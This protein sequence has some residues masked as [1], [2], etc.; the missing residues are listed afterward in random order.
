MD[1]RLSAR[2]H[3]HDWPSIFTRWNYHPEYELHFV[4]KSRGWYIVGDRVGLFSPGH[5]VLIG[6][7]VPHCWMGHTADLVEGR[8]VVFQ[9][10][11]EWIRGCQRVLPELCDIDE[12]LARSSHG[13]EFSGQT[14]E[15]AAVELL[16]IGSALGPRRLQ[17][18]FTLLD[19]LA[20]APENEYELLANEGAPWSPDPYTEAIMGRAI[21]YIFDNLTGVVRLSTAARMADM[22]EAAFSRY[23]KRASGQTFSVMVR[24]L[25]LSQASRL[26]R[27]TASPVATIAREVGYGNISNFNRQF[28]ADYGTTP[29]RYRTSDPAR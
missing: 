9:F 20:A 3:I 12:L 21:R 11:D 7:N 14:A 29:S 26:L 15:R 1:P 22:S 24:R 8:E 28:L 18:I 6:P 23:F 10:P 4:R 19:I 13:V 27:Q 2:W 25:R 16:S 5:L 17:H